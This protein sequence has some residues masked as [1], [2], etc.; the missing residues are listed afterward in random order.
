MGL[1]GMLEIKNIKRLS[2]TECPQLS[3]IDIKCDQLENAILRNNCNLT[4]IYI[5]SKKLMN[6]DCSQCSKLRL[7]NIGIYIFMKCNVLLCSNSCDGDV[8]RLEDKNYS[9]FL[10]RILRYLFNRFHSEN[11][12]KLDLAL[13]LNKLELIDEKYY[14]F[15]STRFNPSGLAN[16][17]S[18]ITKAGTEA[19]RITQQQIIELFMKNEFIDVLSI[20]EMLKVQL[21]CLRVAVN[22]LKTTKVVRPLKE[23]IFREIIKTPELFN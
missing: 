15:G 18:F 1:G 10:T 4:H 13:T 2:I 20:D 9:I 3:T 8:K 17:L 11:L 7:E 22:Y 16:N 14:M 19:L 23:L 21:E 12:Y 5:N 6:L